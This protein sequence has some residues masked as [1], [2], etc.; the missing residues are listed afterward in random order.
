M[1]AADVNH[2]RRS[3]ACVVGPEGFGEHCLNPRLQSREKSQLQVI[4]ST[5]LVQPLVTDPGINPLGAITGPGAGIQ[6]GVK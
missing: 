3:S 6:Y 1:P 5:T 4:T 2:H